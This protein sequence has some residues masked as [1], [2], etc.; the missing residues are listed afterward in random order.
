MTIQLMRI[1]CWIPKATVA[2]LGCVIRI[3][4]SAATVVTRTRLNVKLN[5]HCLSFI[6]VVYLTFVFYIADDGNIVD[7]NVKESIV[8]KTNNFSVKDKAVPLQAW[9]GPEG[10]RKLSL[11]DF[12]TTAQDVGKVGSVTNRPPLPPGNTPGTHFC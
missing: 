1:A 8:L 11:P 6:I 5:V 3:D 12:L 10:S 7:R 9:S 4:F 2:H